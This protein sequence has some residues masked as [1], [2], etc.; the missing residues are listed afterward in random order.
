ME[1]RQLHV[2]DLSTVTGIQQYEHCVQSIFFLGLED[3]EGTIYLSIESDEFNEDIALTNN[4]F[5]IG[6]PMTKF[7]TTYTCQIYG[8]VNDGE[9][10]QLSKQFRMMID[11]SNTIS[12]EAGEYPIDPNIKIGID[13]Y[14]DDV[15]QSIPSDYTALSNTVVGIR[16]QTDA[17]VSVHDK[18]LVI[19]CNDSFTFGSGTTKFGRY[20][21]MG[22]M[23]SGNTRYSIYGEFK[24][25]TGTPTP[26][27][28]YASWYHDPCTLFVIGHR[29]KF[30]YH[31]VS[32]SQ[33][34]NGLTTDHYFDLRTK[35]EINNVVSQKDM[36]TIGKDGIVKSGV[37]TC[38]FQPEM[39]CFNVRKYNF[40]NAIIYLEIVDI[41]AQEQAQAIGHNIPVFE[42]KNKTYTIGHSSGG[43]ASSSDPNIPENSIEGLVQY[44]R[45]G[46]WGVSCD[47]QLTADGE[48]ILMHDIEDGVAR[49]TT[50]TGMVKDLTLAQIKSFNMRKGDNIT[51]YKVPIV[52]EWLLVGRMYGVYLSLQIEEVEN[53]TEQSIHDLVNIINE[54]GMRNQVMLCSFAV[55]PL[56]MIKAYDSRMFTSLL[57]R[58]WVGLNQNELP[59]NIASIAKYGNVGVAVNQDATDFTAENIRE[60]QQRGVRV[61]AWTAYPGQASRART[62][63]VLPY[64]FDFISAEVCPNVLDLIYTEVTA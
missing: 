33:D 43:N 52:R 56:Q 38:T 47:I 3:F 48:W 2:R 61:G 1:T 60:Y 42:S 53:L 41:T 28:T 24:Q 30:D 29:Y 25:G 49:T 64:G 34:A 51:T 14:V 15:I 17:D 63:E 27:G 4:T 57:Y 35:Q 45:Q 8:I 59:A 22:V 11:K 31:V 37:W 23:P 5:I 9:K 39:I 36:V 62:L 7:N 19:P 12:G 55:T 50:G 20:L 54:L 40:T 46:Y 32:G 21:S 44:A 10:I 13:E 16:T 26:V 6:Q 58:N 18:Q